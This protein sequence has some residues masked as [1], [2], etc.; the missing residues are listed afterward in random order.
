VDD[1]PALVWDRRI[2]SRPF[3]LP[4]GHQVTERFAFELVFVRG[5][6]ARADRRPNSR[7]SASGC[8]AVRHHVGSAADAKPTLNRAPGLG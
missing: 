4:D 1:L 3:V 8:F 2:D 6:E 7:V 5:L